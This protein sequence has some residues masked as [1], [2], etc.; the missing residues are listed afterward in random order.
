MA[1]YNT[2]LD[3]AGGEGPEGYGFMPVNVTN[4]G[5]VNWTGKLA[6]GT[7]ITGSTS[8]GPD[9]QIAFQHILYSNTG[10]IQ[11]WLVI[12]VDTGHLDGVVNWFKAEQP[13]KSTTRSYKAGFANPSVTVIGAPYIKPVAAVLDLPTG[14]PLNAKVTMLCSKADFPADAEHLFTI[15]S[16]NI[17]TPDTP[18]DYAMKLSLAATTGTFSGSITLSNEDPT[19]F[20]EPIAIIKRTVSY[21]GILVTREDFNKGAGYFI[22][23]EL[24]FME[25]IPDTDP[26]REKRVTATPQWS[27]SAVFS[28]PSN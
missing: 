20:V 3:P 7:G 16:K 8:L 6:D 15:S 17:V 4:L 18:N 2:A 26:P 1:T 14:D 24:P 10:S 5:A 13:V 11:G 19:D 27:G 28:D 25:P 22:V 12:T 21:T 9:G 23:D